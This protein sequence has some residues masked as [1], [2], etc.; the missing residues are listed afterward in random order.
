MNWP[1]RIGFAPASRQP[2][3]HPKAHEDVVEEGVGSRHAHAVEQGRHGASQGR[4]SH[5]D[6]VCVDSEDDDAKCFLPSLSSTRL[7][8]RWLAEHKLL[9]LLS[10]HLPLIKQEL[11]NDPVQ[12]AVCAGL[13]V[14]LLETPVKGLSGTR[15]AREG[16][17]R[18][19]TKH[20]HA[21]PKGQRQEGHQA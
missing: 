8:I 14:Y 9:R 12:P 17:H 16:Q 20:M 18:Q 7:D 21:L 11:P 2:K 6:L 19:T 15:R 1:G 3:A 13:Q 10:A 4:G 5:L